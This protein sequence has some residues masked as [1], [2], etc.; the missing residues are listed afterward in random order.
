MCSGSNILVPERDP[1]YIKRP[2]EGTLVTDAPYKLGF[3]SDKDYHLD[4]MNLRQ[5]TLAYFQYYAIVAYIV[6]ALGSG[7]VV[8][9]ATHDDR[10][11]HLADLVVHMEYGKVREYVTATRVTAES[12]TLEPT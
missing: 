6:V 5:L 10:Y 12:T 1:A 8:I 7:G 3:W 11:F 4:R 9:A 2:F